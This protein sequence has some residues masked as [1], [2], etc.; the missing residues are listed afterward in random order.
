M[1][2]YNEANTESIDIEIP[3]WMEADRIPHDTLEELASWVRNL[4]YG[5]CASGVYM[6]AVTY[7]TARQTMNEHGD[8]ILEFIESRLDTIPTL[9]GASWSGLCCH[10]VSV[11]V[12]LWAWQVADMTEA[13]E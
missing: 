5:G 1:E 11:A 8:D 13:Y 6:P 2:I 7:H 10:F 9:A 3:A 4:S 12:E